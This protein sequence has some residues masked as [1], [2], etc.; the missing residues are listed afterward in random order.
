M[1]SFWQAVA[2]GALQGITEFLPVSSSGHLVLLREVL[3]VG[4]VPLLFDVL[5]HLSTL[6]ATA[7]V[8]RARLGRLI[9]AGVDLLRSPARRRCSPGDR[10]MVLLLLLCTA[11]TGGIGMAFG[12]FGLPR[13]PRLVSV[14]LLV[15]AALLL[16]ARRLR[17]GAEPGAVAHADAHAGVRAGAR[18]DAGRQ[19]RWPWALLV[20]VVQ[21]LA[22]IPGISRSGAT[23][24]VGV[25]A[26]ADRETAADFSFLASVPAILGAVAVSLPELAALEEAVDPSALGAGMAVSFAAGWLALTALLRIVRRGRLHLFA[27]YLVPVGI[28]GLTLL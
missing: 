8:F 24:A 18:T 15:T 17:G 28:L 9:A 3:A 20:G 19:P 11:V 21:G 22:V 10:R 6:A 1:M 12:S 5:L 7:V 25:L 13:S 26:G 2:L 23:I 14:M 27:L 16:A 4:A